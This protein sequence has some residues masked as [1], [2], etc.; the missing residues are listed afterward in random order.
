MIAREEGVE[1]GWVCVPKALLTDPRL[2]WKAKALW[3]Y[4]TTIERTTPGD[5]RKAGKDSAAAIRSGIAELKALGYIEQ[6]REDGDTHIRLCVPGAQQLDLMA[7]EK[8][9]ATRAMTSEDIA[10]RQQFDEILRAY[11]PRTGPAQRPAAYA[12][13]KKQRKE[14]ALHV[15]MLAAAREYARWCVAEGRANTQYVLSPARFFSSEWHQWFERSSAPEY[16]TTAG[17]MKLL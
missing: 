10:L 14:G 1:G 16:K 13:Y 4:L 17:G 11:P 6:R 15:H 7:V 3:C 8:M 2:S 5:V 9:G 12:A